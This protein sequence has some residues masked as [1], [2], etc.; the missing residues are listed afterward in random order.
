MS[1]GMPQT[2]NQVAVWLPMKKDGLDFKTYDNYQYMHKGIIQSANPL[3]P[4]V[5]YVKNYT[6]KGVRF[7]LCL[8]SLERDTKKMEDFLDEISEK[9][10]L[11]PG[12]VFQKTE[13]FYVG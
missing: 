10:V 8:I 11:E 4:V 13:H 12:T 6:V 2:L 1:A 5:R 7:S 9:V 3:A